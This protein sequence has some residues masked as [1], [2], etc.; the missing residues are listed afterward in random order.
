[1]ASYFL[2]T[3]ADHVVV[4]VLW[5]TSQVDVI[6]VLHE[7]FAVILDEQSKVWPFIGTL[8]PAAQHYVV[9]AA[10]TVRRFLELVAI[11]N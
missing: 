5:K 6:C 2:V 1:M 11:T 8:G 7:K 10:I 4:L 3:E 9:K